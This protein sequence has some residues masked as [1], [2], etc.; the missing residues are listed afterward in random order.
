MIVCGNLEIMSRFVGVTLPHFELRDLKRNALLFEQNVIFE[1][2]GL[3]QLCR[4]SQEYQGQEGPVVAKT[5]QWLEERGVIVGITAYNLG[6]MSPNATPSAEAFRSQINDAMSQY[7]EESERAGTPVLLSEV[8]SGDFIADVMARA[9]ALA[10]RDKI[11]VDAVSTIAPHPLSDRLGATEQDLSGVVRAVLEGLPIPDETTPWE[12]IIDFRDDATAM[13]KLLALRRWM[14]QMATSSTSPTHLTE[15]IEWLLHEYEEHMKLHQLK[16][17]KGA[18]E[19]VVTLAAGL[20]EDIMKLKLRDAVGLLFERNSRRI[21]LMEA[22]RSA[23]GRE[24]AYLSRA[25]SAFGKP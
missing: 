20:L 22:E 12:A 25:K 9:V 24:L 18:L 14:R 19:M 23:P 2:P 5:L 1:L 16:I 6:A 21:A 10:M 3:I 8:G 15:E 11:G 7:I 4:D 17:N 13:T